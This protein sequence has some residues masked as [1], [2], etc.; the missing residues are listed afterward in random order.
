VES[1][2]DLGLG[3]QVSGTLRPDTCDLCYFPAAARNALRYFCG[4]G[5]I[6]IS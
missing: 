2:H 6:F 4:I 5:V 3:S 1:F